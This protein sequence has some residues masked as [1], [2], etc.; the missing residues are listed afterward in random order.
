MPKDQD[1]EYQL[2]LI[3]KPWVKDWMLRWL[4]LAFGAHAPIRQPFRGWIYRE[5]SP[6][7]QQTWAQA[8]LNHHETHAWMTV[9]FIVGVRHSYEQIAAALDSEGL[10]PRAGR[11]WDAI[12][13][14]RILRVQSR[15][16]AEARSAVAWA[17]AIGDRT[18]PGTRCSKAVN[19][20]LH[21]ADQVRIR[22]LAAYLASEAQRVSDSQIIKAAVLLAQP[23]K[24]LLKAYLEIK[25]ADQRYKQ[26]LE[27]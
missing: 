25:G 9:V 22:E 2:T 3:S 10:P 8:S 15:T 18:R 24:R 17:R 27:E 19:I 7:E 11:A 20:Y 23:D 12:V 16:D 1:V 5:L 21:E 4:R 13:V 14:N 6:G 26:E